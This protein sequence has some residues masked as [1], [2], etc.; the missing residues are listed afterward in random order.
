MLN[1]NPHIEITNRAQAL[2]AP[3]EPANILITNE[4]TTKMVGSLCVSMIYTLFT[5]SI[6]GSRLNKILLIGFVIVFVSP[7][8]NAK[9]FVD[10][11]P[12]KIDIWTEAS[13]ASDGDSIIIQNKKY[14]LIGVKAPRKERKQKFNTPGQPL[15]KQAQNRLNTLLAN[16][17]LEIGVEYDEHKMDAFYRG[18]VHL[19]V[20]QKG[21]LVNL[22]ALMIA[23]GYALA[24]SEENKKH[25][26]CYYQAEQFARSEAIALWSLYKNQPELNFP[27]VE[28]SKITLE[29]DSFRI[30]RGKILS[31][32][33]SR[34]NYILNMDTVGIRI[35]KRH[36]DNFDYSKLEQLKGKIVE[37][38]GYG[39]LFNRAMFVKIKSPN[40]ID[41]L[42]EK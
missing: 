7:F 14:R 20:K 5:A 39:F 36:W 30:Y 4:V 1:P 10:C 24:N 9:Q 3:S 2:N 22:N 12:E 41:L 40:S 31:V 17:D 26:Q 33:K 42:R 23:S 38:R 16:H 34:S 25:Q 11:Q 27:I 13:F 21:K 15:A 18:L 28:S 37:V 19:Y 29:D 6:W 8:A 32:Q 35:R